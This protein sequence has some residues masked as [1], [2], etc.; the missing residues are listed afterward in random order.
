MSHSNGIND[1]SLRWLAV[2]LLFLLHYRSFNSTTFILI[3]FQVSAIWY[4]ML[5]HKW[6]MTYTKQLQHLISG[7]MPSDYQNEVTTLTCRKIKPGHEKDYNNWFDVTWH[8]K[9][10]LLATLLLR[11]KQNSAFY[12]GTATSVKNV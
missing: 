7:K 1:I 11:N 6:G 4:C 3:K 8:L 9:E 2:S 12:Q 10:K 5:D